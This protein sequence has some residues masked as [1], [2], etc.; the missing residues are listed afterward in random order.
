M[1]KAARVWKATLADSVYNA[2]RH[3][4]G[5]T[6]P[7]LPVHVDIACK[8]INRAHAIDAMNIAEICLDAVEDGLSSYGRRWND[9]DFTMSTQANVY[10]VEVPEIVVSVTV[11]V[12]EK[13]EATRG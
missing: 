12:S 6:C 13:Q 8:F 1:N 9:R 10:G 5:V 11:G 2:L 3:E 7:A 4:Q